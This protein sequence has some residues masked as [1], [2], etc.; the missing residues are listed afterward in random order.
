LLAG[1]ARRTFWKAGQ[2]LHEDEKRRGY[3]ALTPVVKGYV[4]LL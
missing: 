4:L 2:T 1:E 3:W